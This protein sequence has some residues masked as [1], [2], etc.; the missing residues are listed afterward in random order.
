MLRTIE[1]GRAVLS[2]AA[3]THELWLTTL[4]TVSLTPEDTDVHQ[5]KAAQ[6]L[7]ALSSGSV[8]VARGHGMYFDLA[9]TCNGEK[10][11]SAQAR[12]LAEAIVAA[13]A[14]DQLRLSVT[15]ADT[16]SL[17]TGTFRI[18]VD[19]M[20]DVDSREGESCHR[21]LSN[22]PAIDI[23]PPY[24]VC[25]A[26]LMSIHCSM[27][28][29]ESH[30]K[31]ISPHKRPSTL[32]HDR[33]S[34]QSVRVQPVDPKT[35]LDE[36]IPPDGSS[37]CASYPEPFLN[38]VAAP[39]STVLKRKRSEIAEIEQQSMT[40]NFAFPFSSNPDAYHDVSSTYTKSNSNEFVRLVGAAL[41]LAVHG[42]FSKFL[43]GLK[44][45]ATTFDAGLS[46]IAPS[47]WRI[48]YL[49]TFSQSARMLPTI[50]QSLINVAHANPLST[51]LTMKIGKLASSPS[52]DSTGEPDRAGIALIQ[53]TRERSAFLESHLWIQ[54]QKSFLTK[55]PINAQSFVAE[56]VEHKEDTQDGL[57]PK[58]AKH[59]LV[60]PLF[61]EHAVANSS[62]I[63]VQPKQLKY[64]LMP[65]HAPITIMNS[66]PLQPDVNQGDGHQKEIE[67]IKTHAMVH[68]SD[69]LE[70][71][72]GT[73]QQASL[74]L[75]DSIL[76]T[77]SL[78]AERDG[79][80]RHVHAAPDGRMSRGCGCHDPGPSSA[81][82]HQVPM[83]DHNSP[84]QYDDLLF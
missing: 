67:S 59:L 21:L 62:N 69:F 64:S 74:F 8:Y 45:K 56:R 31:P 40:L 6:L 49:T 79:L 32:K 27:D 41:R 55:P 35:D 23:R 82:P 48:G 77:S 19:H 57:L 24:G 2:S 26:E 5:L 50:G 38:S 46:S 58:D 52:H 36:Q 75:H 84:H 22:V 25:V 10:L 80:V 42:R 43:P 15:L 39:S 29:I 17:C 11:E 20:R 4:I 68:M 18:L 83:L 78:M 60:Q 34:A 63:L 73:M 37:S 16:P 81:C 66:R 44:V 51:S 1:V 7:A 71:D 28:I 3:P 61:P 54:L 72:L 70:S 30:K 53:K 12:G 47:V 33:K 65:Q 76:D 13:P 14:W 9:V